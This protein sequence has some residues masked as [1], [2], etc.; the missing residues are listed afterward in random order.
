[1]EERHNIEP[2]FN[3]NI[4]GL[5]GEDSLSGVV[6]DREFKGSRELRLDGIFIE[7][8]ADPRV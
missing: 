6:L 3:A 5:K 7:I 1:M 2:I 4:I 8:V